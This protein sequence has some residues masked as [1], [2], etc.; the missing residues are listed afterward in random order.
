MAINEREALCLSCKFRKFDLNE[1]LLCSITSKAADFEL[2]CVNYINEELLIQNRNIKLN[3]TI[4]TGKI[5][6]LIVVGIY[7]CSTLIFFFH[8][9]YS[10]SNSDKSIDIAIDFIVN[11]WLLYMI[12]KGR[13]WAK[14][15][16][17]FILFLYLFLVI[18]VG[19]S[20]VNL[21]VISFVLLGSILLF[22]F[23]LYIMF[24]DS[25]FKEYFKY[26]KKLY[27]A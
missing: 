24:I 19:F 15:I 20:Y 10:N 8:S 14:I 7:I 12:S 2:N 27:K 9:L 25:D 26:Q 22:F 1:G 6:F 3:K 4:T 11:N 13:N 17:G 23:P 18:S 16:F 21:I 5:K